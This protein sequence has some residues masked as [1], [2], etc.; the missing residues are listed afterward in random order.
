M[1]DPFWVVSGD[2]T[3][4]LFKKKGSGTRGAASAT[5]S[6]F[7][8][9]DPSSSSSRG[10]LGGSSSRPTSVFAAGDGWSTTKKRPLEL[11]GSVSGSGIEIAPFIEDYF[12][13]C[14]LEDAPPSD[15]LDG[16]RFE[17]LNVRDP[18]E[19]STRDRPSSSS[20][21]GVVSQFS[22]RFSMP[23]KHKKQA[24]FASTP[25][26]NS[27]SAY[28][29]TLPI[30]RHVQS[31]VDMQSDD[32][33]PADEDDC[34]DDTVGNLVARGHN[35]MA[36]ADQLTGRRSLTPQS[37]R[38]QQ[39]HVSS[40]CRSTPL[41]GTVEPAFGTPVPPHAVATQG[42]VACH[43]PCLASGLSSASSFMELP[44]EMLA[45][46]LSFL[47]TIPSLTRC[48]G[49]S[50]AMYKIAHS[51]ELWT[52]VDTRTR[53]AMGTSTL[54]SR[55]L[56]NLAARRSK[57]QLQSKSSSGGIDDSCVCR[58]ARRSPLL[59]TLVV[60]SVFLAPAMTGGCLVD[61]AGFCP[62]LQVLDMCP[63]VGVPA[64]MLVHLLRSCKKL[65]QVRISGLYGGGL[66]LGLN[67][68]AIETMDQ[69]KWPLRFPNLR[70]VCFASCASL[71]D[72]DILA[73]GR[74]APNMTSFRVMS[75]PLLTNKS[76]HA[77]GMYCKR[78]RNVCIGSNMSALR[79]S[80]ISDISPLLV[81]A[82]STGTGGKIISRGG[83]AKAKVDAAGLQN[84]ALCFCCVDLLN[85]SASFVK[86]KAAI[87]RAPPLQSLQLSLMNLFVPSGVPEAAMQE[88]AG[89]LGSLLAM[90]LNDCSI[91]RR[92]M[93]ALVSFVP[94]LRK[95]RIGT[96]PED[97][98][99]DRNGITGSLPPVLDETILPIALLQNLQSLD[100]STPLLNIA[101]PGTLVAIGQGCVHLK[102][103][104]LSAGSI[105][106]AH[107]HTLGKA[108][109]NLQKLVLSHC[110]L[111]SSA[112]RYGGGSN[113]SAS[114]LF[115]SL[116]GLVL[117]Q[118]SV[119]GVVCSAGAGANGVNLNAP[120]VPYPKLRFLVL[121]HTCEIT[122]V[123]MATFS[124]RKCQFLVRAPGSVRGWESSEVL[125]ANGKKTRILKGWQPSTKFLG[126][127][128]S[129]ASSV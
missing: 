46:C 96:T 28:N 41:F 14:S 50:R 47:D 26:T 2:E 66:R 17:S 102:D 93:Q 5:S 61:V 7:A 112:F 105:T 35:T 95:L 70:D 16:V 104:H 43:Q 31:D 124:S 119:D 114:S 128:E 13:R 98:F 68:V 30:S 122:E 75:T 79:S 85:L 12:G 74:S 40:I 109:P 81:A 8:S 59:K 110:K 19:R 99:S 20:R 126:A 111:T 77:L 76:V 58:I 84:L 1:A 82:A 64:H 36:T 24:L 80:V 87:G 101:S 107:V 108:F 57:T 34:D 29:P 6:V 42:K 52:R 60:E 72:C 38:S 25:Y 90:D 44:E 92:T 18:S 56:E 94:S 11:D 88:R 4:S 117:K 118:C 123:S 48:G 9:G 120:A 97:I 115:P 103:V 62:N 113:A 78:L 21:S 49:T 23:R 54:G 100:L 15:D 3:S 71:E 89:S 39:A 73:F 67:S 125:A 53:S 129:M 27:Q 106:D 51:A 45:I 83:D 121:D 32:V 69:K 91:D 127:L 63:D 65:K 22:E 37:S 33:A 86:A 116:L 55:Y 10:A